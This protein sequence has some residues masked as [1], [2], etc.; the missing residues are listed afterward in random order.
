MPSFATP[1]DFSDR[2]PIA[3]L[4]RG[5]RGAVRKACHRP[6]PPSHVI[7]NNPSKQSTKDRLTPFIGAWRQRRSSAPYGAPAAATSPC[8]AF[9]NKLPLIPNSYLISFL[10][11]LTHTSRVAALS[12][13]EKTLR[14][15]RWQ[16]PCQSNPIDLLGAEAAPGETRP[17]GP[18]ATLRAPPPG[19]S[20]VVAARA[21][22]SSVDT[23][24]SN[25]SKTA[26]ERLLLAELAPLNFEAV[27]N[28]YTGDAGG[29]WADLSFK[30][31]LLPS[32]L[33]KPPARGLCNACT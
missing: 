23:A 17:P 18:T 19:Q 9:M 13:R 32:A 10:L 7:D 3:S 1:A 12:H 26:F 28:A 30:P 22:E 15:V 25:P 21:V 8:R 5:V 29:E 31:E 24:I 14:T 27:K 11:N 4:S 16:H 6:R 33:A 2:P 20:S